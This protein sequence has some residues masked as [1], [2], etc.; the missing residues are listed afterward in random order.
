MNIIRIILCFVLILS[1]NSCR[2]IDSII[3][4]NAPLSWKV[5]KIDKGLVHYSYQ[6]YSKNA[7]SNQSINILAIDLRR[8]DFSL[9]FEYH[10]QADSLSSKALNIPNSLAAINGTY[11]E[12]NPDSPLRSSFFKTNDTIKSDINLPPNHIL[13][14]KHEGVFY[15]DKNN[16][17]LGIVYGDN[18][19]YLKMKYKN[20]I[21]GSPILINN[22]EPVGINFVDAS[23]KNY[24]KLD[25]ENPNRH[26]GVRHP[27]TAIAIIPEDIL[28]L[29]T[30]D[31]R[32]DEAV[33]MTAK[34]LTMML[35]DNFNPAYALNIDG[36][37]STTMWI[38][39]AKVS[40]TG[41]VNYPTANKR[42]DHY[43]QRKVVNSIFLIKE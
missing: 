29:I 19:M 28:L 21:S 17:E 16:N 36:G 6:G 11:Y 9:L 41:V 7:A 43:G 15:Y 4:Q 30:V 13:D 35:R 37:G 32:S 10:H 1:F 18:E 23:I 27:R 2:N 31:G 25:Y 39:N 12:M 42:F 14:W 24:D 22:Y 8:K 33:G 3:T 40:T 38:K 26:Q 20:I 5:E 34:E